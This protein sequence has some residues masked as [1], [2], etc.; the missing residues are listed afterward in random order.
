MSFVNSKSGRADDAG[1]TGGVHPAYNF[2]AEIYQDTRQFRV[3]SKSL[4]RICSG[5][6]I[7]M[8]KKV[9]MAKRSGQPRNIIVVISTRSG[10]HVLKFHASSR[11]SK[12][13]IIREFAVNRL[14]AKHD[15][16]VPAMY[17]SGSQN[18]FIE[19]GGY[20]VT[21]YE[22][23]QGRPLHKRVSFRELIKL[24][25]IVSRLN[26]VLGG[27]ESEGFPGNDIFSARVKMLIRDS[28]SLAPFE[29]KVL[30]N[31]VLSDA[32]KFYARSPQSFIRKLIHGDL[33]ELNIRLSDGSFYILDLVSVRVDYMLSDLASLVISC[34][35]INM[36]VPR[37]LKMIRR[38]FIINRLGPRQL[39]L[40][41]LFVRLGFV[42]R[43][44]VNIKR[45]NIK[46]SK[47]A[48]ELVAKRH[49]ELVRGI[50]AI[51]FVAS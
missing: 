6:R 34:F 41:T 42:E 26:R 44:L 38:Y 25:E 32:C 31:E 47:Q 4:E 23:I 8:P 10:K 19:D 12:N 1:H 29:A 35:D 15:I 9:E 5:F 33:R 48:N 7:G 21:G 22:F 46:L 27:L 2:Y 51:K 13:D 17:V 39:L 45:S 11:E 3:P 50:E 40:L 18:P 14:L 30:V 43:Y 20:L 37:I 24:I 49:Q 36:P 16:P 28:S